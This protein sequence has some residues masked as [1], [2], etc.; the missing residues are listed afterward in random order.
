MAA[1]AAETGAAG[2]LAAR[3]RALPDLSRLRDRR[4]PEALPPGGVSLPLTT[5]PA[6]PRPDAPWGCTIARHP[7]DVPGTSPGWPIRLGFG[8]DAGPNAPDAIEPR[9]GAG[10]GS[11][12][13]AC[14]RDGLTFPRG[15]KRSSN[16]H[17]SV[18][19]IMALVRRS[20]F[21]PKISHLPPCLF[22]VQFT[23]QSGNPMGNAPCPDVLP[24]VI[25]R[26]R[27]KLRA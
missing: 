20:T 18:K 21:L 9:R 17:D 7:Y 3:R 15:R 4:A 14:G 1:P 5:A 27:G 11:W 26:F 2:S 6:C 8:Q 13:L 10:T 25:H 19:R 16:C 23:D 22:L 24:R 12:L